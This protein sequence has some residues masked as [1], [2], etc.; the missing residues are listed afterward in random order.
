MA[1]THKMKAM[2]TRGNE[3]VSSE[4]SYSVESEANI[5]LTIPASSTDLLVA[6]A[7]DV[8]QLKTLMIV[9]TGGDLLLETNSGSVPDD[10]LTIKDG[11]P[12]FWTHDCGLPN[13]FSDD[14][15]GLYVTKAG[16]GDVTFEL[17]AGVDPTV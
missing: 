4:K 14:I 2:F 5:S 12:L 17:R 11:I 16:V 7:V 10:T 13:P 8:S 1:F 6:L 15:N 3:V 9:A